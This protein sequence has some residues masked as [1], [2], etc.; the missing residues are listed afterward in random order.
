[1]LGNVAC[2]G[3]EMA[4]LSLVPGD[5]VPIGVWTMGATPPLAPNGVDAESFYRAILILFALYL[6]GPPLASAVVAG[7]VAGMAFKGARVATGLG[8]GFVV[9]I[10]GSLTNF[11]AFMF[12]VNTSP[13]TY[14]NLVFITTIVGICLLSAAVTSYLTW[15]G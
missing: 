10:L 14:S 1:M 12:I 6:L 9:G 4:H 8:I 15:R 13:D 5:Y 11:F 2:R 7:G 3:S